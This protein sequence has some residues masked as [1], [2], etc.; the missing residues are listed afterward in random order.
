[1]K[2]FKRN[3]FFHQDRIAMR[4]AAR[5]GMTYEYKLARRHRLNPVEALEDWD[6]I[7]PED[8]TLF[9]NK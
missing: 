8:Y 7:T 5:Y 3:K 1:M 9:N 2:I 4:I 6:L